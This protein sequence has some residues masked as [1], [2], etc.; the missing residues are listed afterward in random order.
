MT[1][2]SPSL[3]VERLDDDAQIDY[4]IIVR[5]PVVV[6]AQ[7]DHGEVVVGRRHHGDG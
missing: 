5:L 6:R 3:T 1:C 2:P 7:L 4:N